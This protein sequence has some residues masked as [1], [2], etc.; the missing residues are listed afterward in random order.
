MGVTNLNAIPFPE[1]T[2]AVANGALAMKNI[3]QAVD[4]LVSPAGS[5]IAFAGATAPSGWLLCNGTTVSRTT[6][7]KLFTLIGTTYNTGGE[8]GT[9][10]RLPNLLGRVPVGRDA[11]QTE[12]DTLGERG[13]AKTHTLTQAEQATMPVYYG[14][15]TAPLDNYGSASGGAGGGYVGNIVSSINNAAAR[16]YAYGGGGAHNNLQPYIALNYI[17]KT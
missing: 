2:D 14:N 17:I 10:F 1:N 8:A 12:F 13:G 4:P 6:Y 7:A 11:S 3:A 9:D 16:L 5:V 15:L